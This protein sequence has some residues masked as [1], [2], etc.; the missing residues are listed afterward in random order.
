MM[1]IMMIIII[2]IKYIVKYTFTECDRIEVII[3]TNVH[4]GI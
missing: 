2:I 1:M 3:R 4:L